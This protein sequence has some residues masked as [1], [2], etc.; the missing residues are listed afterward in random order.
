MVDIGTGYLVQMDGLQAEA[1]FARKAKYIKEKQD[2]VS[3]VKL[4]AGRLVGN[5]LKWWIAPTD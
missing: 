2:E 1:Y 3:R 5:L 4:G